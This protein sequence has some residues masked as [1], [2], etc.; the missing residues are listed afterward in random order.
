MTFDSGNLYLDIS[1]ALVQKGP[2]ERNFNE[3]S[4]LE[5]YHGLKQ[6]RAQNKPT[7]KMESELHKRVSI[8][9]ACLLFGLIGAPL[10]IRRTR[11]G[12]SAGIAI[13]LLCFCSI[14]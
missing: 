4:T 7:V 13:A 2:S 12:K 14:I 10:G 5:L 11:S 8:P 6:A 1:Q 3:M 9:F